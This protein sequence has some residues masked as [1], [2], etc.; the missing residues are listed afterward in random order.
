MAYFLIKNYG[1]SC[2]N[3]FYIIFSDKDVDRAL[4]SLNEKQIELVDLVKLVELVDLVKLVEL[5][6]LVDLVEVVELIELVKH[7]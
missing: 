3:F 1:F 7:G 4:L 2:G 6:K 5:V